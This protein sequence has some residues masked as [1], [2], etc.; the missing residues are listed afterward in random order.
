MNESAVSLGDRD[1]LVAVYTEPSGSVHGDVPALLFLN[2]GIVQRS[3]PF[4]M[5]VD[6]ARRLAERGFPCLRFDLAGIGDS[7]NR[8]EDL[9]DEQGSARDVRLAM[10]FLQSQAGI[11]RFILLGLCSGAD[12]AHYVAVRDERIAGIIA[13][14]GYAYPKIGYYFR[15]LERMVRNP[16]HTFRRTADLLRSFSIVRALFGTPANWERPSPVRMF[17]RDLPPQEQ[18]AKEIQS[19]VDRGAQALYIFAGG[20]PWYTSAGQFYRNYP[21][22]RHNRRV[23]VEYF[24]NADHTYVLVEDRK[25][26]IDR[27][28]TWVTTRFSESPERAELPFSTQTANRPL[29]PE[30]CAV[31]LSTPHS[32]RAI[33]V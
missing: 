5:Y 6:I 30:R 28:E 22:L 14:D 8:S 29:V 18:V 4:R 32:E 26:L 27:V 23:E 25:K 3:G 21:A 1:K 12:V 10:E 17:E 33:S 19:F 9:S 13:L 15:R 11:R 2:A 24:K 20:C 31:D 7:A 16:G